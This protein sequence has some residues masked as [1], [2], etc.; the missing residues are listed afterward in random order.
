MILC[1]AEQ[2]G[3][4]TTGPSLGSPSPLSAIEMALERLEH[5]E[6]LERPEQ[7]W[8]ARVEKGDKKNF[9]EE[10][11][12]LLTVPNGRP[13][14]FPVGNLSQRVATIS[15]FFSSTSSKRWAA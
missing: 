3:K 5:F 11:L 10:R 4:E 12:C 1:H 9:S 13:G 8:V 15:G 2:P 7:V 6:R 14:G